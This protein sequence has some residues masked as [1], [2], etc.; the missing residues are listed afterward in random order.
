MIE[1][2]S[3]EQRFVDEMINS[4]FKAVFPE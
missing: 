2:G 4:N 1:D 3:V